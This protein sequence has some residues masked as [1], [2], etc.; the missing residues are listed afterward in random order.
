MLLPHL[1]FGRRDI[2]FPSCQSCCLILCTPKMTVTYLISKCNKKAGQVQLLC[3]FDQ[4]A[5]LP[6]ASTCV[7]H[8]FRQEKTSSSAKKSVVPSLLISLSPSGAEGL[9]ALLWHM[10]PPSFWDGAPG[11]LGQWPF[12][13]C[14]EQH[15]TQS[16]Q[17]TIT[18][19]S[20]KQNPT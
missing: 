8:P 20:L 5:R 4:G 18:S 12:P 16:R 2:F 14:P 17:L 1:I 11:G 15:Q 19:F 6:S 7:L 10:Q 3:P 9:E 13:H